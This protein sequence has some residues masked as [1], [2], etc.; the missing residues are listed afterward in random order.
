MCHRKIGA[1]EISPDL[2]RFERKQPQVN[3]FG[4]LSGLL[5]YLCSFSNNSENIL[6]H[7]LIKKLFVLAGLSNILGVLICSKFLTND[8]MMGAQPSIM[9]V[10][11]L[12]AIILWGV[13]YISISNS[14]RHVPWLIAVFVIEKLAYVIAWL[15]FM[16]LNSIVAIY[17]QDFL[18]GLFYTIYGVN[19]LIFMLFFAYIFYVILKA[20]IT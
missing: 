2:V 1:G 10:F 4:S 16:S 3:F 5:L 18:A 14:Y 19:D 8:V 7:T 17:E 15:T 9:G 6:P 13:A 20:K 11:G 12:I